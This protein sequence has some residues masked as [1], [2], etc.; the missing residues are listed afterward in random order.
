MVVWSQFW[1]SFLCKRPLRG[2]RRWG[3]RGPARAQSNIPLSILLTLLWQKI[4]VGLFSDFYSQTFALSEAGCRRHAILLSRR[5]CCVPMFGWSRGSEW[6]KCDVLNGAMFHGSYRE[7]P[8]KKSLSAVVSGCSYRVVR[9]LVVRELGVRVLG[10]VSFHFHEKEERGEE[11]FYFDRSFTRK[12]AVAPCH[13]RFRRSCTAPGRAPTTT[14]PTTPL[15]PPPVENDQNAET[16]GGRCNQGEGRDSGQGNGGNTHLW[17]YMNLRRSAVSF[18]APCR[19][20]LARLS[21]CH[22]LFLAF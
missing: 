10:I 13:Q 14:P 1:Q 9:E 17:S 21:A 3:C 16:E 12:I 8:K 2:R 11:R 7:V 15:P 18:H 4:N 5:A 6:G 19:F 22:F 20:P